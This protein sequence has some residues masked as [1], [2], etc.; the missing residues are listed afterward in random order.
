M[1][2]LHFSAMAWLLIH[3]FCKFSVYIFFLN[4]LKLRLQLPHAKLTLDSF[5]CLVYAPFGF[6]ALKHLMNF[7]SN[8]FDLERAWR[9]LFQKHAYVVRTKFG[10]T[11][12]NVPQQCWRYIT[13]WLFTEDYFR[14]YIVSDEP[15]DTNKNNYSRVTRSYFYTEIRKY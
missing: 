1:S 3:N 8:H 15:I 12:L 6:D 5:G 7:A 4:V 11:C 14:E 13:I 10:I 9:R 2:S